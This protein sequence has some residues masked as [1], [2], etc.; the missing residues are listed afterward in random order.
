L[1]SETG[2]AHNVAHLG[3]LEIIGIITIASSQSVCVPAL[4]RL[5]ISLLLLKTIEGIIYSSSHFLKLKL[6]SIIKKYGIKNITIFLIGIIVLI[7]GI[8][9]VVLMSAFLKRFENRIR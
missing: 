9:G 8:G 6:N 7:L 1:R 3:E 2:V 5:M 4:G